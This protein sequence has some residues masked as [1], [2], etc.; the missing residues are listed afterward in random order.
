[1]RCTQ[2]NDSSEAG[3]VARSVPTWPDSVPGAPH[4]RATTRRGGRLLWGKEGGFGDVGRGP[5]RWWGAASVRADWAARPDAQRDLSEVTS[6][7]PLWTWASPTV[8]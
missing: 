5:G 2:R 4:L 6:E 1:M 3:L 8:P 7:V